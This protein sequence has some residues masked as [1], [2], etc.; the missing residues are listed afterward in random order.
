MG[1]AII[2]SGDDNGQGANVKA[3]S[4]PAVAGD[5]ALVVAL[6]PNNPVTTSPPT[7]VA[8]TTG[9]TD[10]RVHSVAGTNA[11][12]LKASAGN[13]YGFILS[14]RATK[15]RFLKFY[16]KAS[17]PVVGTDTPK[18]TLLLPVS[19]TLSWEPKFPVFFT[20]GIAYALTS[21]V[22]DSD[23]GSIALDDIHGEITWF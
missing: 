4:T 11:T 14:N 18:F 1:Q 6:S 10:S 9:T 7:P 13:L 3:P 12:S 15:A 2:F 23:T 22:A 5:S 16:D 17:A 8:T 20:L 21:N 19:D